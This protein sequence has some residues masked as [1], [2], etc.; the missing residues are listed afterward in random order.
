MENPIIV[1]GARGNIGKEVVAQ[2]RTR[3]HIVVAASRSPS[4]SDDEGIIH[5]H[6]DFTVAETWNQALAGVDKVFLV[7]PPHIS[8]IGRD[9]APFLRE[10]KRRAIE[11]VVFLSVQGAESNSLV[12]H[13]KIENLLNE[14]V[15]PSTMVRP[16]FFMENL[17]TTHLT[18]IRDEGRLFIPAGNGRTNFI[19]GRD[20][21]EIAANTLLEPGHIG[22]GYTITGPESFSYH[23]IA[24]KLSSA[25]GRPIE[26]TNPNPFWFIGYHL[27]KGRSLSMTLVM[28]ALYSVVK[29]GNADITTSTSEEILGRPPRSL[30]QFIADN[31]SS[32]NGNYGTEQ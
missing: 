32:F 10:L 16:S 31:S 22:M 20:I 21:G 6:F 18:E 23:Q 9:M 1:T 15:I 7:R 13:Q 19:D 28:L 24:S 25:L 2:L 29:S 5:R 12:P 3:G 30:D 17:T 11:Q 26:Y 27:K 14:L 4:Q 8:N